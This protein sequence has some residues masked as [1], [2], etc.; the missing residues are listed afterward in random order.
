MC[1]RDS[2]NSGL[3]G[4][5]ADENYSK[6]LY[7]VSLLT[8]PD[9]EYLH[10]GG[11]TLCDGIKGDDNYKSK[12]WLGFKDENLEL[13]INLNEKKEIRAIN[14]IGMVNKEL[15]IVAP[16]NIKLFSSPTGET[17][18]YK[19]VYKRQFLDFEEVCYPLEYWMDSISD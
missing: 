4:F 18:S 12:K 16:E 5:V 8:T 13:L 17:N 1:I 15:N 6:A 9:P 14:I 2:N 7:G 11:I 19:D 3:E 10:E